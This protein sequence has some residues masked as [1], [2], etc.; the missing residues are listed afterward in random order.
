M[1]PTLRDADRIYYKRHLA[2]VRQWEMSVR[3][4]EPCAACGEPKWKHDVT[5]GPRVSAYK[6][7]GR[8]LTWFRSR[9]GGA[10]WPV[11]FRE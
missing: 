4:T 8:H 10:A 5:V 9:R 2:M 3:L 7:T 11:E 1:T 6:C